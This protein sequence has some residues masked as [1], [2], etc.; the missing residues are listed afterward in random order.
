MSRCDVPAFEIHFSDS[1]HLPFSKGNILDPDLVPATAR[2]GIGF[3]YDPWS[4]HGKHTVTLFASCRFLDR[5]ALENCFF[6]LSLCKHTV[7]QAILFF[8]LEYCI[9]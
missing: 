5:I 9:K 6:G 1:I 2:H 3:L 7:A 8:K 4:S